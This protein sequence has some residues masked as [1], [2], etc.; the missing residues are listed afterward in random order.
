MGGAGGAAV[1]RVVL[2]DL[3][4]LG[5]DLQEVGP[6]VVVAEAEHPVAG[7]HVAHA[8]GGTGEVGGRVAGRG[9]IHHRCACA[10]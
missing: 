2:D 3:R 9:T 4:P 10:Y 6:T 1:I 5:L 8:N 7:V